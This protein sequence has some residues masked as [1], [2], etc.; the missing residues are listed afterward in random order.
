MLAQDAGPY[1]S[2][3]PRAIGLTV[4]FAVSGML[5]ALIIGAVAELR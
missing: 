2:R 1:L 3:F 5:W 4:A